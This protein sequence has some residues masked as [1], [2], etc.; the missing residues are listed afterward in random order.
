MARNY[1]PW[2]RPLLRAAAAGES[3]AGVA[4][5]TVDRPDSIADH[6]ADLWLLSFFDHL[7]PAIGIPGRGL[8]VDQIRDLTS[9]GRW[10]AAAM[11][12]EGSGWRVAGSWA[13]G[14]G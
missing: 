10:V 7:D 12:R 4:A 3:A 9:N 8:P 1:G 13:W 2:W 5:Q 14:A 11:A 6:G